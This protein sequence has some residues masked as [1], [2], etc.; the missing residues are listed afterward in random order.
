MGLL[1]SQF[2][3]PKGLI[4]RI[5]GFIMYRENAAISKW[6]LSFL[7]IQSDEHVL[8]IGF[9][10][11]YCIRSLCKTYRDIHVTGL[12]PSGTMVEEAT[13]RNQ[14]WVDEG[15]VELKEAKAGEVDVVSKPIDKVITINNITYWEDPVR[16]LNNLKTRMRKAGRI[17][18][19]LQPHEKGASDQTAE[20]AG[21]QIRSFLEQ[22]GFE[23]VRVHHRP[24]KPNKTTCVVGSAP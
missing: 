16:T 7:D 4:G 14:K 8:E 3:K 6:T 11:G 13:R 24:G 1:F 2:S 22:A 20:L 21:D 10:P 15:R 18:I 5:V 19:T 23:Y 17:A 12:D 9:G